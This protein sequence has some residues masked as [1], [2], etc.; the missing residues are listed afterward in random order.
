MTKYDTRKSATKGEEPSGS[1]RSANL[2]RNSLLAAVSGAEGLRS[3]LLGQSWFQS[4]LMPAMPR[5]LRWLLRKVYLAPIDLG[6]RLLG[7]SDPSLPAK[8]I[9]FT[10]SA[11]PDFTSRGDALVKALGDLAGMTPSSRVLDVGCGVG[12]LAI[13]MT[14]YLDKDGSYEGL[15]IVPEAI[16]WCKKQIV[17]AYGNVH[18][19]LADVYNK[20]YNPKGRMQPAD[21][22][23]P[24]DDETFDVVALYSVFTHMLPADVDQYVGEIARVLKTNGRIFATNFIINPESQRMMRSS[25]CAMQFKRNLGS[26]WIQNGRVPELAVAYNEDY[27]RELHAKHGL[28]SPKIYDGT[29]CGRPGYWPGDSGFGNQDVLVAV[30]Q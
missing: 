23:F 13:A 30:K 16:E 4:V 18:F 24:Y 10:G 19:T 14:H 8:A 12:K 3:W 6:D 1:S 22:R 28:S 17:G 26:Y 2:M 27:I 29:W 11:G 21:Y 15:D 5:Q 25:G 9:N 7:R 20:E